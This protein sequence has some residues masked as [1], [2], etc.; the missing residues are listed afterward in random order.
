MENLIIFGLAAA[1]VVTAAWNLLRQRPQP[2][3]IIY[4]QTVPSEASGT[5]CLPLVVLIAVILVILV[6]LQPS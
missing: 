6:A 2:P 3:Q 4:V 1:V 5:G